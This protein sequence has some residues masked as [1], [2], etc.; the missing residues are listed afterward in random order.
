MLFTTHSYDK[1]TTLC[2][3]QLYGKL[4]ATFLP[5]ES[6]TYYMESAITQ[7]SSDPEDTIIS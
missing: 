3:Q 4:D 2:I 7:C 6:T 5:D 1:T